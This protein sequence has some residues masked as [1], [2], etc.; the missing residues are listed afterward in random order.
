MEIKIIDYTIEMYVK[1]ANVFMAKF[2]LCSLTCL[3]FDYLI[4]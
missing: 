2:F 3:Y 1:C 4:I